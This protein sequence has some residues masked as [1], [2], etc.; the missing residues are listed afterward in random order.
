LAAKELRQMLHSTTVAWK[1]L[2]THRLL[3][4]KP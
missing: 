4:H 1:S 3:T 2:Y